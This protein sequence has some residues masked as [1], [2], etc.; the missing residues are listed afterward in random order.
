MEHINSWSKRAKCAGVYGPLTHKYCS[1]CPVLSEC[2]GYAVVHQ[3]RGFW[4]GT[5]ESERTPEALSYEVINALRSAFREQGLLEDRD[6]L[7]ADEELQETRRQE[8]SVPIVHLVPSRDSNP[9]LS[10]EEPA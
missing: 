4:G 8:L 5:F 7:L 9:D 3:E 1:D 6:Y 10:L 2:Y